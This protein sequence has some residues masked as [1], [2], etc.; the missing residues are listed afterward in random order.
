MA[1]VQFAAATG[2]ISLVA[3]TAKTALQ[4]IAA[5]NHRLEIHE[6]TVSFNGIVNTNEPVLVQIVRQTNSGTASSLTPKKMNTADDET[7]QVTA[8]S[9][10]SAEPTSTDVLFSQLVHPQGG[11]TWQAPY[12]GNI[13]VPGGT[14]LGIKLTAPDALSCVVGIR[15]EE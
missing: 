6:W 3:D 9:D 15:G 11:Y 4:V 2:A 12:R 8:S 5:A 1:G 14:R 13:S 10:A 7:L